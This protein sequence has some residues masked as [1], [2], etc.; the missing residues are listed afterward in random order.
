MHKQWCMNRSPWMVQAH[1]T[2]S[3]VQRGTWGRDGLKNSGQKSPLSSPSRGGATSLSQPGGKTNL[4]TFSGSPLHEAP[5]RPLSYLGHFIRAKASPF[6]EVSGSRKP[7]KVL[8]T[9]DP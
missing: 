6:M 9:F 5:P 1:S 4:I 2:L 8:Y 3:G 7:T